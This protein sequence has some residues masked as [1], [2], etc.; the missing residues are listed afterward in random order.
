MI[1]EIKQHRRACLQPFKRK[2]FDDVM[3]PKEFY[4][5]AKSILHNIIRKRMET[6]MLT[7]LPA[8]VLVSVGILWAAT[9]LAVYADAIAER[10]NISRSWIGLLFVSIVT[11]LPEGAVTIGSLLHVG[12]PE[13][14]VSNNFGSIMFNLMVIALVDLFF[15]RGGFLRMLREE[16]ALPVACAIFMLV[17]V[18]GMLL[19]PFPLRFGPFH[20]GAGAI[21]SIVVFFGLFFFM[22][23]FE[24]RAIL[25]EAAPKPQTNNVAPLKHPITGF[26]LCGLIVIVCATALAH[27]GDRIAETLEM[28]HP[29]IGFMLL[30]VISSLPELTFGISAAR[31]RAYDLLL[32]NIMGANMINALFIAMADTIH[33][34]EVLQA[35]DIIGMEQVFTGMLALLASTMI[36]IGI[37]NRGRKARRRFVGINSGLL[38]II[39]LICVL[40]MYF[41][42][43]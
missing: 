28:R 14:A 41:G 20:V 34:R 8:L 27:L 10:F 21:L 22:Q 1:F 40:S 37:I 36:L 23:H 12:R 19:F 42:L 30:A 6:N 15:L 16:N 26:I 35:P 29:F 39:Y 11:T 7:L 3:A 32:G 24:A 5:T 43:K 9:R 17:L 4:L 25:P 13:L 18:I 2:L 33:W 38:L 31:L